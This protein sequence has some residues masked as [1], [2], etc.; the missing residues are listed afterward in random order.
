VRLALLSDIHANLQ[1][2]EAVLADVQGCRITNIVSL[3]DNIGYGPQPQEVTDLLERQKIPSLM[4]NHEFALAYGRYYYSLNPT[5]RT[6]IDITRKLLTA[7]A[8]REVAELP[9]FKIIDGC[10]CVH[11]CPPDSVTQY[12]FAPSDDK[13]RHLLSLFSERICFFGHTHNLALY[14][15]DHEGSIINRRLGRERFVV[16]PGS[17]CLVNIGS[18]GQPRDG[19]SH[20]KYAIYDSTDSS[21]EIRFI[22][23][24]IEKTKKLILERGLPEFNAMRLG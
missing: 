10:R 15:V 12:L 18:I 16:G 2:L 21:I 13:L 14:G 8:R 22:A 5:A 7:K 19:D 11:G 17:R 1:A 20:A 9:S 4:G 6:S 23:Y 24:D 3:G